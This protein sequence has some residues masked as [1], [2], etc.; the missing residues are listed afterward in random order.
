MET[1]FASNDVGSVIK[2]DSWQECSDHC[3]EHPDCHAWSYTYEAHPTT[4]LHKN[5]HMKNAN[6][7]AGKKAAAGT[8]SG[9]K[10]L[11]YGRFFISSNFVCFLFS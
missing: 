1:N 3:S 5:C 11:G 8:H 4:A 10:G 2:K 7:N 9:L 6:F